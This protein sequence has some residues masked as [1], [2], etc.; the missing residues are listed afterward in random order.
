MKT[1]S[2]YITIPSAKGA[3]VLEGI[4]HVD[5]IIIMAVGQCSMVTLID[6]LYSDMDTDAY[7]MKLRNVT[8][9]LK[10]DGSYQFHS[11]STGFITAVEKDFEDTLAGVVMAEAGRVNVEKGYVKPGSAHPKVGVALLLTKEFGASEL[12]VSSVL[13]AM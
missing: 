11:L 7:D 2:T 4:Q 5:D 8:I 9:T 13:D 1:Q 6:G 10:A 3:I 12:A